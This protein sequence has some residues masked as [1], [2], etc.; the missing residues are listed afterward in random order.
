[1]TR[2]R[3]GGGGRELGKRSRE[4]R[5]RPKGGREGGRLLAHSLGRRR[6]ASAHSVRLS[7]SPVGE[8]RESNQ[9]GL[10]SHPP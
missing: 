6:L 8:N 9:Q 3:P 1:M 2:P 4:E 10:A 5:E 7:I